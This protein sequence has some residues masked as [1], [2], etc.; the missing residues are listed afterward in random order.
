MKPKSFDDIEIGDKIEIDDEKS[1]LHGVRRKVNN[2]DKYGVY[3]SC[4]GRQ[5]IIDDV[6]AIRRVMKP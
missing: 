1:F 6:S 4:D 5:W 2:K 3:I